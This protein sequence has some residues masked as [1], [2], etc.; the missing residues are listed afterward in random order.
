MNPKKKPNVFRER[1]LI[2]I[3]TVVIVSPLTWGFKDFIDNS[4]KLDADHLVIGMVS[5]P[6]ITNAHDYKD[7]IDHF[8]KKLGTET[9]Y[10]LKF[11]EID[12]NKLPV[13]KEEAY[14]MLEQRAFNAA[15]KLKDKEWDLAFTVS[16]MLS[17]TAEENDYRFVAPMSE[18][19]VA[20]RS[21]FFV[22]K[23]SEILSFN[24]F[25]RRYEIA[26]GDVDNPFSSPYNF[27]V[28]FFQLN[29][30]VLKKVRRDIS[31]LEII[32]LVDNEE[33]DIGVGNRAIIDEIINLEDKFRIIPP[34][35]KEKEISPAGVYLSPKLSPG[36][37]D[38]I[39][40]ALEN[41]PLDVIKKAKYS[42][43]KEKPDYKDLKEIK[44]R[45][46]EIRTDCPQWK[47]EPALFYELHDC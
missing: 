8:K 14:K 13:D 5:Y 43:G 25:D 35:N 10:E 17:L 16:P 11:I 23:D 47:D 1:L 37:R 30:K 34:R 2:A 19:A 6:P 41:A 39:T 26:L 40:R 18:D 4:Q 7:L 15:G 12:F 42:M 28:P 29:G 38:K 33:I 45:V 21:V 3:S 9:E 36:D 32:D 27:Y 46:D 24:D 22:R 31:E 44:D 20:F